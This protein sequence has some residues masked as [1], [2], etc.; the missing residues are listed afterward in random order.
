MDAIG[1]QTT[2]AEK[3]VDADADY[4]LTLKKNQE[5]L[6]AITED[7]FNDPD[8]M[9]EIAYDYHKSVDKGHGRLEI[10]EC[11]TTSDPAYLQYIGEWADWKG[12]RS[13]VMVKSERRIG[14][15]STTEC[16]YFISSLESDAELM[17]D[18]VRTHWEIENKVHWVLDIGFREDESRVRQGNA[19]QNLSLLRHMALNLLKQETTAQCGTK[20]KRLKAGWDQDYLLKVLSG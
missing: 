15:E 19:A 8:E 14:E 1:C 12:L 11:W 5:R 2:I 20:A 17:L 16:R 7:L 10:R 3:T 18:T 9:D 6:Y 4:V 13:L